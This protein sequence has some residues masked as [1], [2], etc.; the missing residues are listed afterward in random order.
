MTEEAAPFTV[1]IVSGCDPGNTAYYRCFHEQE[2][3]TLY[4]IPRNG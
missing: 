1:Y 4:G 3:L 2:Q